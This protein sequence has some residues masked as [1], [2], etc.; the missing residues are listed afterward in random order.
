MPQ[1]AFHKVRNR[2]ANPRISDVIMFQCKRRVPLTKQSHLEVY[3][4]A[5]LE[6]LITLPPPCLTEGFFGGVGAVAVVLVGGGGVG[7]GGRG[8]SL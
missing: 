8:V 3:L 2:S 1:D 4:V 5:V 6:L 7:G